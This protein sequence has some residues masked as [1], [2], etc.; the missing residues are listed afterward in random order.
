MVAPTITSLSPLSGTTAGGNPVVL[1]GKNFNTPA[2]T[3]VTFDG[4]SATFTI[5]SDEQITATAPTHPAGSVTVTVTNANGSATAGY[6]YGSGLTLSPTQGPTGGGTVVDI[7]GMG[8]A[9]ANSVLFGCTAARS[10]TQ[11]SATHLQAVSPAGGGEVHV[12]VMAKGT[13]SA[14]AYFYYNPAP[15]TSGINPVAGP[16][17]RGTAVTI[18]GQNLYTTTAVTF[19]GIPATSFAVVSDSQVTA[20]PPARAA[21]GSVQVKV[22]TAGGVAGILSFTYD[23]TPTISGLSPSSGSTNGGDTI[24]I[25]G[26]NL[27]DT[28]AVTFGG[29]PAHFGVIDSNTVTAIT[30]PSPAGPAD[31]TV[32]TP[33]GTATDPGAFTYQAPPGG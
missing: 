19:G 1:K 25:N 30:P 32:T 7:Y 2:V 20:M 6:S 15:F 16:L 11:L 24:T 21:P 10:F 22:T 8:L 9:G 13:A 31:M 26:T 17:A 14:P 23:T 33:G 12:V 29:N 3:S 28:K 18:T 27:A 4:N 5:N